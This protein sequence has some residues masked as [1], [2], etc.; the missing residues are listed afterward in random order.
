MNRL[1]SAV[2]AILWLCSAHLAHAQAQ[3]TVQVLETYPAGDEVTLVRNQN[4]YLRL[5]YATDQPI[6]IWAEPYFEGQ[7]AKA[8]SNPSRTYEGNGE[9]LGWFFLMDADAQVDE[10]RIRA[11]DGTADGTHE[12]ARYAVHVQAS[13]AA[14]NGADKPEWVERMSALDAQAQRADYEK[15]MNKAP[16]SGDAALFG[17]FMLAMLALLLLGF[18]APAWGLWRWRG[19]WRLAAAVPA[20]LMAFVV[21]RII[22]GTAIDPTSHNLWPFEVLIA[23]ALSSAAMAVLAILRRIWP[24][25]DA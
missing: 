19:G 5:G 23:G 8:G 11:G 9:A 16:S 20:V 18:A 6:Q 14:A 3:P 1:F 12:V 17:G 4:F 10:V 15:R 7:R 13:D 22:T 21:L 2:C 24:P 25:R